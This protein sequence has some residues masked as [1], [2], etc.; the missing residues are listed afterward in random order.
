MNRNHRRKYFVQTLFILMIAGLFILPGSANLLN[1][2]EKEATHASTVEEMIIYV[3]DNNTVG[4]WDGTMEYPYQFIQDGID[5]AIGGDTVY[6][7]NG[8]Y[9]E[10]VVICKTLDLVGEDRDN[11]VITGDDFGT[12]VKIVADCVTITGFTITGSGSNPNNAGIMVHT[13]Y[14]TIMNNNIQKNNYYGLY[15]IAAD[16]TIYHNNIVQN[17]Y[18]AFDEIGGSCW[19]NG[20]PTGGNYWS[21]YTGT[22]EDEDG[23][24]EIPYPTGNC[25]ADCYPLIHPYGSVYNDNTKEIFLTIQA[26]ICDPDTQCGHVIIVK[27]GEYWEHVFI[28]KSLTI[29]GEDAHETRID[30]R[31][32]GD[33]VSI[34]A[35]DV[36][37][38][39]FMVQHSGTEE[40]NAGVI[41]SGKD[42]SLF[43]TIIYENYQGIV[44]KFSAEDTTI[45]YNEIMNNGWNGIT[46]KAGCRGTHIYENTIGENFYA[47]IG[48]SEA[49]NNYVYHNTFS[50]NRYQAYD[51]AENVWDDGYPS[52]G[53]YWSDYTGSDAN[54]DGIGD[55]PYVIPDGISIDRY[56]LMAPYMAE[57]MIPPMVSI[58]S[59]ENGVYIRGLHILS[60]LFKQRTII[61]GPIT[62]DVEASDAQSGVKKVEF[63]IDNSYQP[64]F[65]DTQEPYSWTW[66]KGTL[67]HHKH[68]I[69]VVAYDNADNPNYDMIDVLRFR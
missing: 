34:C 65:T 24:G 9:T 44:L 43:H 54:G 42:C 20:Y 53:N 32:T 68:S 67:L 50:A 1:G 22:D 58:V 69:I 15:V 27:N 56:P 37:F 23:I 36:I 40:Q 46:L 18:Q 4:P 51:D 7:F 31:G 10:N 47:G 12:V 21:D 30:G 5:H 14:N 62:I 48:V 17:C 38:K 60:G 25:S 11:T 52:G 66:S 39:G 35:C 64:A 63:Y 6:V 61:I 26:A 41:I 29:M 19:D 2:I 8:T 3:D 45:A 55:T 59:P 28:F 13:S 49:S 33:V 57:D 16:N